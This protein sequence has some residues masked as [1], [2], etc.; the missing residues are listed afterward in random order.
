MRCF[1]VASASARLKE[2]LAVLA[3][4]RAGF[5]APVRGEAKRARP[6]HVQSAAADVSQEL[7]G[8][9]ENVCQCVSFNETGRRW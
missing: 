1:E 8:L 7:L 3:D 6:E 5:G 9:T 2:M 4:V